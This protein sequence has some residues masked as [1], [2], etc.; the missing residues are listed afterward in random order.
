MGI[1][2]TPKRHLPH[3]KTQKNAQR[4]SHS[5]GLNNLTDWVRVD[6][7]LVGVFFVGV[8]ICCYLFF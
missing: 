2:P 3:H 7:G 6:L 8:C 5:T 1:A 4:M